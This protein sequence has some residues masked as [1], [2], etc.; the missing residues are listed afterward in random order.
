MPTVTQA[1]QATASI[2]RSDRDG[3]VQ[4]LLDYFRAVNDRDF[5]QAYRLW[6]GQGAASQQSYDQFAA[7]YATTVQITAQLGSASEDG[8][9]QNRSVTVPVTLASVVNQPSG[10]QVVQHYEGSYTVQP[11]PGGWAIISAS[12]DQVQAGPEPPADLADPLTVLRSYFEAINAGQFER[13]YTYWGNL[14]QNSQQTFA[15]FHQGFATTKEVTADLGT[16]QEGG[17]AG[18]IYADVPAVIVATQSDGSVRSFCGT[19]TLRR[20]NVPPFEQFGW[21]IEMAKVQTTANVQP[22][23]DAAKALL[24]GGCK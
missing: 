2:N 22:G 13:A 10:D 12:V 21:H 3:A 23:S 9:G 19:Y 20:L 24:S 15:Q 17:A 14:G 16:A 18:S 8:V 1:A 5:A 7:G 6:A 11:G 4:A